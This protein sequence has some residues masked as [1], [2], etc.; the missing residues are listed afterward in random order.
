MHRKKPETPQKALPEKLDFNCL[1][2]L[3]TADPPPKGRICIMQVL[4]LKDVEQEKAQAAAA[5]GEQ[6]PPKSE[7]E[8]MKAVKYK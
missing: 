4:S 7:K 8:R 2:E 1:K 5:E 6:G 3:L